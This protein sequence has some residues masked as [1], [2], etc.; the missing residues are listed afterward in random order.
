[1]HSG[2][3]TNTLPLILGF[4]KPEHT[5]SP[6]LLPINENDPFVVSVVSR[7]LSVCCRLSMKCDSTAVSIV[8]FF[9]LFPDHIRARFML[10]LL[11]FFR[12]LIS[13]SALRPSLEFSRQTLANEGL[14]SF[15]LVI[16]VL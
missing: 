11:G 14:A 3:L 2:P 15:I 8:C 13:D 5:H 12:P 4:N 6:K 10:R 7:A 1:M 9:Q 16:V